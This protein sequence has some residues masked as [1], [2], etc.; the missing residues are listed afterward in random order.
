MVENWDSTNLGIIGDGFHVFHG[1]IQV[2]KGMLFHSHSA[3]PPCCSLIT[4]SK[5]PWHLKFSMRLPKEKKK[6]KG[7]KAGDAQRDWLVAGVQL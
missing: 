7:L 4:R 6:R 2:I 1:I 3:F 5:N